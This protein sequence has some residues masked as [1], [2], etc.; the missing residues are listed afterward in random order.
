LKIKIPVEKSLL[1]IDHSL[2]LAWYHANK[3]EM[4]WRGHPDPYAVWV[5]EI[6]LQQTRVDTVRPYFANFMARFPDVASLA[7]ASDDTLLK[8]W[9]GLGYYTRAHNLRKA[10]QRLAA[11]H[12]GALPADPAELEKLPG[13]GTYTSAAI[14]SICFGVPAPVV[15]GNVIRV[16]SR[17]LA[18]PGD[19]KKPAEAAKIREWLAPQIRAAESPGDFNQAMMELGAVVCS[20]KAPACGKCPL[21][22]QCAAHRDGTL[23]NFP[24]RPPQKELPVR[25]FAALLLRDSEGR[26]LLAQR[27][28]RRL[29]NGLW[30]LPCGETPRPATTADAKRVYASLF[31]KPP[32]FVLKRGGLVTHVFSHFKQKMRVFAGDVNH[33][34]VPPA[35][36]WT[37]DPSSLPLATTTRRA[38]E[39]QPA[40]LRRARRSRPTPMRNVE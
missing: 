34:D 30:E 26:V 6:M 3:R 1:N 13:I 21:S 32:P 22:P 33:K 36:A 9:E 7:K 27:S 28:G 12:N 19:F 24:T 16:V 18:W 5:S 23:E 31:K 35:F 2:L 8:A 14:A 4:P 40:F 29:L 10:A 25:H 37:L 20:P 38:L 39:F 15:D 17:L 11:E